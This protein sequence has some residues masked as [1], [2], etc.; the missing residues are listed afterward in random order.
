MRDGRDRQFLVLFLYRGV[1]CTTYH[2]APDR[3]RAR[4]GFL[5][6]WKG[7]RVLDVLPGQVAEELLCEEVAE[8]RR[9][10]AGLYA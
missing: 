4:E 6:V 2:P 8:R 10:G 5:T 7:A 3:G 1:E 9:C